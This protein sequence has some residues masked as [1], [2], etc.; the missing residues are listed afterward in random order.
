MLEQEYDIGQLVVFK[1][2]VY[3]LY[4]IKESKATLVPQD[5][6]DFQEG[7]LHL[8]QAIMVDMKRVSPY[9]NN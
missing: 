7:I 4:E 6:M 8:G 2:K 9:E 5:A 3:W 1:N